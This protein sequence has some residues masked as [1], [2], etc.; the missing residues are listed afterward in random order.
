MSMNISIPDDLYGKA[1]ELAHAKKVSVDEI[2]AAAFSQHL[3]TLDRLR[4]RAKR[5]SRDNFLAVL[6]RVP[7]VEPAE[8]DRL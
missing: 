3:A 8:W 4:D 6:D 2:V 7:D 1:V 5:G